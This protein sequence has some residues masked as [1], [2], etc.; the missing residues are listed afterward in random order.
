MAPRKR[1]STKPRAKSSRRRKQEEKEAA[2]AAQAAAEA[3]AEAE[4]AR[5]TQNERPEAFRAWSYGADDVLEHYGVELSQ[6][7]TDEQV[8][9]QRQIWGP[10]ELDKEDP[11]SMWELFVEQFDDPLV[12]I[13]LAAAAVSFVIAYTD[14]M[15]AE[16]EG[17]PG[18]TEGEGLTAFVEPAVILLILILNA[19]VGV[20]QESNA[21]SALEALKDLQ[22]RTCRVWR[23]G[24]EFNPKLLAAE[25]VPGDVVHLQAGDMIP[26]DSR[27]I[28][29]KTTTF[30]VEQASLTGE[31]M[32]VFKEKEAVEAGY[33]VIQDK[34]CMAF[35]GTMCAPGE[36]IAVVQATGMQ[37]EFGQIQAQIQEARKDAEDDDTPLGLKLKD[38]GEQLTWCI[39]IVCLLVFAIKAKPG[40]AGGFISKDYTFDGR[41]CVTGFKVAVALAVAAIP[42]GLPAVITTCLALG[43]R[44]MAKKNALVRKL[45]SVETLGCTTVICSDKTGTLTTNKMAVTTLLTCSASKSVISYAATGSTYNPKDGEISEATLPPAG[46][47]T[48]KSRAKSKGRT[49][50]VSNAGGTSAI[51]MAARICALCNDSTITANNENDDD[52]DDDRSSSASVTRD[53]SPTEAALRVLAE[54]IA[55]TLGLV[56]GGDAGVAC[57]ASDAFDQVCPRVCKLEFNRRRK[58]MSVLCFTG[59]SSTKKKRRSK[60]THSN[61]NT[62]FCKG[63][64]ESVL[65]RCSHV[66]LEDGSVAKLTKSLRSEITENIQVLSGR[67]LRCLGLAYNDDLVSLPSG[68]SA[69]GDYDGS[70]SHAGHEILKEA[71]IEVEVEN[72]M[73]FVGVAAMRDP[74]RAA[75]SQAIEDCKR[76]GVR[77]IV[78][79]GDNQKTAEAICTQIGLF[80]EGEDLS[81]RSFVGFDFASLSDQEKIEL[82][83]EA[84]DLGS[85]MV[86]SRAEP[87]FKQD[88]V[89]MLKGA[90]LS[91]IC[92]M[93]G[94]GVNDAPAL[95]AADIGIAMGIAGTEVA[96][97]AS[98]M[99]LADDNFATIVAAIEEGRAIY[100]NMKAF[101]RYMISSNIGEVASIFITAALG[102]PDGL[103]PVQLLWVNLV[104]DGPP[105]TA[106]G[107]NPPDQ[108][109]GTPT[110][111]S[112]RLFCVCFALCLHHAYRFCHCPQVLS[113][114]CCL[115][116]R[117]PFHVIIS[118]VVFQD[119][120]DKPPRSSKDSLINRWTFLR[121]M[122]VGLYVGVATVGIF[123]VWY[124]RTDF[125]GIDF[126]GDGH[127]VITWDQLSNS[128]SCGK[129]NL[130]FW[131]NF[132]T[133][134][135]SF[136]T[137]DPTDDTRTFT[138]CEY[139]EEGKVKA[140]T[141]SLSVL[142][143]IEM[144]NALNALSEDNSL[145]VMRPW[146]NPYLIAAMVLSFALH[147]MILHVAWFAK[148]FSIVPL[149][150]SEW[151]LVLL[152]SFPVIIIDEVLKAIGRRMEQARREASELKD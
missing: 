62:L 87:K 72:K 39:G 139:L 77:V 102:L 52:D 82:L 92:A 66:L 108:V 24:G 120:M 105:A 69:L 18:H 136:T 29:L 111:A 8:E 93:T 51:E 68:L 116:L 79:T 110:F 63:A 148:L 113:N 114:S 130:P 101:I 83:T 56:D 42:E 48:K 67:A 64:P 57:P 5:D 70:E 128:G 122:I 88:I 47:S 135:F 19:I 58:S 7:L 37:T 123:V 45:P 104:T 50:G 78:I 2:E 150:W 26:A 11:K 76:A 41:A 143:T 65:D 117:L 98:D 103:I 90:E 151:Q 10:N 46:T 86:F 36:A 152:F 75:V 84:K 54:K 40:I 132:E 133:Q 28:E 15:G 4:E 134:S 49:V 21:E 14:T 127:Q 34:H 91:E 73:I 96:Q 89:N 13:L 145:L 3:E 97:E 12:K 20:W 9:Q 6:G 32:V 59:A 17:A 126:G 118:F 85:G 35:S 137:A 43:T 125:M 74:P 142:V 71:G 149:T 27:I 44:K 30:G 107:F 144:L 31:S 140:S 124:L 141:L 61:E 23:N 115:P 80:E 55:S 100:N 38:F 131:E 138:G 112:S 16:E 95:A 94:D 109:R 147:F 60:K 121:Y 53:G 119:I 33:A 25:L 146:I 129:E 99:V 81:R 1:S 106:L 22:P